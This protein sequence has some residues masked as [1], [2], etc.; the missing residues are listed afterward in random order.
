MTLEK[1][2]GPTKAFRKENGKWTFH[3]FPNGDAQEFGEFDTQEAADDASVKVLFV[4]QA[5]GY[6]YDIT[7]E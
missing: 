2:P 6:T 4:W 3:I 1:R 5:D 7:T